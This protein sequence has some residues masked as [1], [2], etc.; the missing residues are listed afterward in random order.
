MQLICSLLTVLPYLTYLTT[1]QSIEGH[2]MKSVIFVQMY[3]AQFAILKPNQ[4]R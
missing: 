1:R 2:I 4:K 3:C